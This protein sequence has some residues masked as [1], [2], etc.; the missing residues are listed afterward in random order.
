MLRKRNTPEPRQF[1]VKELADT[2]HLVETR[3]AK[4]EEQDSNAKRFTKV[5]KMLKL[6]NAIKKFTKKK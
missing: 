2:F 5:Y 4:F 3:M 1:R 6:F